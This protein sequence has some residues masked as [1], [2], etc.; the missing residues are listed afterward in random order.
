[1]QGLGVRQNILGSGPAGSNVD[2]P[3]PLTKLPRIYVTVLSLEQNGILPSKNVDSYFHS[4]QLGR[5]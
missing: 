4:I 2:F 3:Q 1:M 5:G